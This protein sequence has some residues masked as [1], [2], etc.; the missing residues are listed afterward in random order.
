VELSKNTALQ[1]LIC[2]NNLLTELQLSKNSALKS[3]D[4]A[5]NQ[6]S[7]LDTSFNLALQILI[8]N[9]N[10]LDELY[11]SQ[12]AALQ[13]FICSNNLLAELELLKKT[14]LI[15]LSCDSNRITELDLSHNTA[16]SSLDCR[17]NYLISEEAVIG[18]EAIQGQLTSYRFFPQ[19][20]GQP[21]TGKD[22]TNSF[23]D[24]NFLAAVRELTNR[25][26]GP[27]YDQDVANITA[28][29]LGGRNISSLAGI[30]HF[31]NLFTLYCGDNQL[32]EIDVSN[33][34]ALIML[35]CYNNRLTQLDVSN[36]AALL[37]L[38]CYQ[39]QLTK[40]DISYNTALIVLSCSYNY[41]PSEAAIIGLEAIKDRLTYYD[42]YPQYSKAMIAC[43]GQV[44]YQT[45]PVPATAE[46]YDSKGD[47]IKSVASAADGTFTFFAPAGSGYTLKVT[48]PGYLSYT[49]KN[50]TL[51]EGEVIETVDMR[52]MAG[53]ING[54]GVVNAIDLTQLLSE[55]NRA[56]QKYFYADIDGN[57]M[58]NAIDLTYL[59]AGF[60]KRDVVIDK[61]Q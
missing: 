45:S 39:N 42:F 15:R 46:L 52:Q 18:L 20:A 41:L 47:L 10:R 61:G 30:E 25:P 6:L 14:A 37:A 19:Y 2:K 29:E 11:L 28:L 24:A 26:G 49:V 58:V 7:S 43:H 31:G 44:L 55:F 9:D 23:T 57:G 40:L 53:D 12:D 36:N 54:D 50:L 56:P 38:N 35:V 5:N 17:Y 27:I 59:L 4:C 33:N 3:L 21:P 1:I 34:K 16:L 13:V 8:C 32:S 51:T 22:I 60:N 48:K